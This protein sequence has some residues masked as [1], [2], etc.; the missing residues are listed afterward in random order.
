[1]ITIS[2][3]VYLGQRRHQLRGTVN[4]GGDQHGAAAHQA[5][6]AAALPCCCFQ[7]AVDLWGA[8]GCASGSDMVA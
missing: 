7:L 4:Q 2:R 3:T 6:I 8:P 1:M 5:N